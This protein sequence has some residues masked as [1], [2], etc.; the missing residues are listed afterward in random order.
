MLVAFDTLEYVK[1]L[2]Q[3]GFSDEQAD[4][5]AKAQKKVISESI[6][7]QIATKSDIIGIETRLALV[8]KLLWAV[9]AGVIAIVLKSYFL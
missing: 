2:K 9:V 5:L 3:S 1:E 4:G 7:S 6:E 8:E